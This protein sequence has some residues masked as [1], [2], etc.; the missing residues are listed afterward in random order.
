MS[1]AI[2]APAH[3]D[4]LKALLDQPFAS[5]FNHARP[6][7]NLVLGKLLIPNMSVMSLEIGLHLKEGG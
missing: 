2:F 1:K 7:G 4:P 3:P 6:E 5:T